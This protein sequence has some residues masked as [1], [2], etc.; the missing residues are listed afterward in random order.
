MVS[1]QVCLGGRNQS[2][3]HD[4]IYNTIKQLQVCWYG[5]PSDEEM[6]LQFTIAAGP[7]QRSH[8]VINWF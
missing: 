5:A 8:S 2:G 4:R 7:H 1:R 3:A 6:S